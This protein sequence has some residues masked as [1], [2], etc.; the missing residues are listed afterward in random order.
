MQG[1]SLERLGLW[2]CAR[3]VLYHQQVKQARCLH[4]WLSFL[5]DDDFS[6]TERNEW[7]VPS[8]VK[9]L[10]RGRP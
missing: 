3:A 6:A 7:E 10:L 4:G 1:P 2:V 8:C 9:R 5:R